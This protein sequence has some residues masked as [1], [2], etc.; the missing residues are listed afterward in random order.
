MY[1]YTIQQLKDAGLFKFLW[2]F[3]ITQHERVNKIHVDG[4][5]LALQETIKNKIKRL[6]AYYRLTFFLPYFLFMLHDMYY[7][8]YNNYY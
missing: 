3:G 8:I 2:R 7:Y 5:F 1:T 6:V 4:Y